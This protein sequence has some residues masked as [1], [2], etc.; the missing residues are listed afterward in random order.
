MEFNIEIHA[1]KLKEIN[2]KYTQNDRAGKIAKS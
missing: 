1:H 2:D